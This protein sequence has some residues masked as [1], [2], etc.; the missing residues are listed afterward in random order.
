MC[1]N[2]LTFDAG[3][4]AADFADAKGTLPAPAV[5]GPL[6]PIQPHMVAARCYG[7][8]LRV[9]VKPGLPVP[10]R[11]PGGILHMEDIAFFW[12]DIRADANRRVAAL[13]SM[14]RRR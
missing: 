2:P 7:G 4:P 3:R 5:A 12:A 13:Q 9:T 6:P 10:D 8:V 11:L 1:T 14:E